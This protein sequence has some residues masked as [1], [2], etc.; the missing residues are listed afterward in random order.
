[1]PP[2]R[3]LVPKYKKQED[4]HQGKDMQLKISAIEEQIAFE[5]GQRTELLAQ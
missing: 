4:L 1:V 3:V 2:R 5:K